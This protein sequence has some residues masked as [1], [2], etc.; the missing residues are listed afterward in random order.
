MEHLNPETLAR[1]VDEAPDAEERAHLERCR[2]CAEEFEWIRSTSEALGRLPDVRPPRGD[3]A[4]LEAR[5]VSEGLVRGERGWAAALARTPGWMRAAAAVVLFLSGAGVG[6]AVGAPG[7]PMRSAGVEAGMDVGF[8]S[9]EPVTV[10]EAAEAMR[11]AERVFVDALLRY[12]QMVDSESGDPGLVD[13]QRRY[14]AL[15]YFLAA[16]EAAVR[17]A[18]TDPFMNGLLASVRAERQAAR[19]AAVRQASQ[20]DWY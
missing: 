3:W 17:E 13:P 1:L 8:V 12:R 9:V 11:R 5:L 2:E 15:E 7:T 6:L 20:Q 10:D 16:G 14:A 18:P 19:Q 4:V